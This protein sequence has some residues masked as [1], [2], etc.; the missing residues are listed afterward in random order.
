M[1]KEQ[2]FIDALVMILQETISNDE[3]KLIEKYRKREGVTLGTNQDLDKSFQHKQHASNF[4]SKWPSRQPTIRDRKISTDRLNRSDNAVQA[5]FP[6]D[7]LG[8]IICS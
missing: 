3:L 2:Y 7:K 6:A 8:I 5:N 4:S 1:L